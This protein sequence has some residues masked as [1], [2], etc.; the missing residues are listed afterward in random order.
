[1]TQKTQM[2]QDAIKAARLPLYNAL[3]ALGVDYAFNNCS[4]ADID[5][6][7]ETVWDAVRMHMQLLTVKGNVPF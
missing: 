5:G 6:I 1:M 2:E 4:A 7:I 3:K